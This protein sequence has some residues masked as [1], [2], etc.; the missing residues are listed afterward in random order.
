MCNFEINMYT[1]LLIPCLFKKI[2]GFECP[3]CGIQRAFILLL[4]GQIVDSMH[5]YPALIPTI[6]MLIYFIY[7]KYY[8]ANKNKADYVLIALFII[9]SLIVSINYIYKLLYGKLSC[10]I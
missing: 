4:K 7:S 6:F 1:L 10:N 9:V 3:G 8:I 2:F 5:M